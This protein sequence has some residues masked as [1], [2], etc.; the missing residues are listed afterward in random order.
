MPRNLII[1]FIIIFA[2]ILRS[3]YSSSLPEI[4]F[5][6][7]VSWQSTTH[8]QTLG[9]TSGDLSPVVPQGYTEMPVSHKRRGCEGGEYS[10]RKGV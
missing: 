3:Q 2:S 1:I 7:A 4:V 9:L 5:Q 6:D 10:L 8:I